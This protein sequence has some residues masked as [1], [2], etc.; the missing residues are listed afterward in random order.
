MIPID[1]HSRNK[2]D[3]G[4]VNYEYFWVNYSSKIGYIKLFYFP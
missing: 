1:F 4:Q 2:N 3:Y